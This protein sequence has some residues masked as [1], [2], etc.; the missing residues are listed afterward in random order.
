MRNF[1]LLEQM[2]RPWVVAHRGY[3]GSYPENTLVAF[4][5]AIRANSDMIELDVSLTRD[6][7]PVVIHDNTLNRTT[8]G[9]G[10]VS[11]HSLAELKKLDAGSWFSTKFRGEAIPTLEEL[12]IS[13]KG[14][15]AVNIEI[16]QESFESPAI[17]N[18]IESQIC[19]IVENLDM[20]DSVLISSFEHS[21][22][23]R[24]RKWYQ[25]QG[26]LT[27]PRIAP[28]QDGPLSE[29][30]ALELSLRHGAFSY[31]PDESF[32]TQSLIKKLKKGDIGI[33]PYTINNEKRM[34]QLIQWGV[35]GIISDEPELVWEAIRKQVPN[36]VKKNNRFSEKI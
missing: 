14:R 12:L 19:E 20:V 2:N 16:K 7:I 4:E 22:F 15:I 10:R 33:L 3:R 32:V 27:F 25:T 31:N 1:K 28:L 11:E 36:R 29:N 18:G 13:V 5:G 9:S 8:N 34:E 26:K 17:S 6:R 35:T 24:I 30:L 23:S 21:F